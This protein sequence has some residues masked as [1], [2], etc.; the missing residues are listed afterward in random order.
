MKSFRTELEDLNN[1]VVE[2]DIVDLNRKIELFSNG[3]ID[4]DKFKSLRLARGV[5]GQRQTGVQM[6]RIKIPFGKITTKQ[7]RRVADISEEYG[8][9]NLHATTRQD[10]QIH[11]VSLDKT[12]ELWAKLEKD[13]ITLREACGNTVRNITASPKAGVDPDEPFDVS[14]YANELFKYLLRNPVSQDFGRKIKISFSSSEKDTGLSFIHDIGFIPKLINNERGFRVMIGG[15]LGAQP[16]SAQLAYEFL[17]ENKII[18][19]TEALLRVFDRYGERKR[20]VKARMKFL[21]ADIGVDRL[22]E[23]V[24]EEWKYIKYKDYS[25]NVETISLIPELPSVDNFGNNDLDLNEKAFELWLKANVFEQKQKEYYGV[26]IKV[27]NGDISAITAHQ[28]AD[29]V[30]Q[31]AAKEFRITANQGY[32]LRFVQKE[33]L[34]ALY[35]NLFDIGL[36]DSGF[37]STADITACPGTD[38][39]NLGIS[40]STTVALALERVIEKEFPEFIV[41]QDVKIKISGCPNSCGQHG[42]AS[43]GF[44]GSSL[45]N[46]LNNKVLP[47]LQV[48]LGGG[49]KSNGEGF[50]AEKVIKVPSKKGANVLRELLN[51]YEENGLEDEYFAYYYQRQ[52]KD[53][54]YQLLKPHANLESLEPKD[55][56]D[57]GKEGI[58]A[59][60][61]E[62]GECAGVIID[63]VSTL[64]FEAEEKIDLGKAAFVQE[65]FSDSIYHSYSAYINGAK[66]LLT[67]K[68]IEGN[69]HIGIMNLF[70]GKF[71]GEQFE[72]DQKGFK[73][74]VLEIN[75]NEASNDF[76][77]TY[78]AGAMNFVSAIN[79]YLKK[80]ETS[81]LVS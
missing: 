29:I 53:Y 40:N 12:P 58:F 24:E 42:I 63:L 49:I 4:E 13:D 32:S 76:A 15:G 73:S 65:A 27:P 19:F 46:R 78:L 44:H 18:P 22:L 31:F 20:R 55:Y 59:V 23:L 74:I 64:V 38:S 5:Y 14:P 35:N 7:L 68:G 28:L 72:I 8:S 1:P 56:I 66:A 57:W 39:C 41:N 51:D 10:I 43:I 34:K 2:Q 61:T 69:T 47:A 9:G 3:K 52:G 11:Y 60:Q 16:I 30:D 71:D 45:K 6:V 81:E 37:D 79:T 54:F 17:P 26:N 50:I 70:E 75:K 62:V 48:L 80:E 21:L 25:I 77:Q 67:S 36:A 33:A